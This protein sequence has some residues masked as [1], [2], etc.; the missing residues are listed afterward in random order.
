MNLSQ[1]IGPPHTTGTTD[2]GL[3]DLIADTMGTNGQ[4]VSLGRQAGLIQY[5]TPSI[6]GVVFTALI[7]EG[8][9]DLSTT[10]GKVEVSGHA[11]T[12]TLTSGPLSIGLGYGSAEG[13]TEAAQPARIEADVT[14]VGGSYNFGAATVKYAYGTR[15]RSQHR[16]F[17][18]HIHRSRK[19][20]NTFSG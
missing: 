13:G 7:A 11:L 15:E 12:A 16:C 19:T 6:G 17:S 3:S 10:A 14:W 1:K 20:L 9:S 5:S 2:S 18:T 4:G 8:S